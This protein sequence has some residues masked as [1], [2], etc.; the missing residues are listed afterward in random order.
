MGTCV[1]TA[2]GGSRIRSGFEVGVSA[3]IKVPGSPLRDLTQRSPNSVR[4]R[5]NGKQGRWE[6]TEELFV[7]V[8]ETRKTKL[9]TV[10]EHKRRSINRKMGLPSHPASHLDTYTARPPSIQH[11]IHSPQQRAHRRAS[12]LQHP[13]ADHVSIGRIHPVDGTETPLPLTSSL[14][15]HSRFASLTLCANQQVASW[16]GRSVPLCFLYSCRSVS[17]GRNKPDT[18]MCGHQRILI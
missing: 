6:E 4:V 3:R 10:G 7:Q 2:R 1:S 12:W 18:L 15:Q 17:F 11:V 9:T 13:M 5:I 8:M 16:F 14:C